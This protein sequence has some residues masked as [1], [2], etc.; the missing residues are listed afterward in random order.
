MAI[1][2]P[3]CLRLLP[4]RWGSRAA[5]GWSCLFAP[6]TGTSLPG[7][8]DGVVEGG[9][10]PLRCQY[11]AQRLLLQFLV[12]AA[13]FCAC[14]PWGCVWA[15]SCRVFCTDLPFP[16]PQ[17]FVETLD[18]CFENVCELDLIFHMDKVGCR[19][20]AL[21][22]APACPGALPSLEPVLLRTG[23]ASP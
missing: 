7:R 12:R 19:L 23:A 10:S 18:K 3:R 11:G 8:G 6:G 21:L 13:G 9:L 14:G 17:V 22:P 4:R 5:P 1:P 20:C 16:P 2:D 15:A